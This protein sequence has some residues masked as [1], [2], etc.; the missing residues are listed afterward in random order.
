MLAGAD[1]ARYERL[2]PSAQCSIFSYFPPPLPP[3][4]LGLKTSRSPLP[5]AHS[6]FFSNSQSFPNPLSSL[7]LSLLVRALAQTMIEEGLPWQQVR[8]VKVRSQQKTGT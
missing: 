4:S 5:L 6:L 1:I 7:T 3:S 8:A 2:V